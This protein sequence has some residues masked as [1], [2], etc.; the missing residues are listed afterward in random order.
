MKIYK[1]RD[2]SERTEAEMETYRL[3]CRLGIGYERV[4]HDAAATISD[5]AEIDEAL[6]T[7]MCKNLF[8]CNSQKTKFYLLLMP[9]G[10]RFKTKALSAFLQIP[11]LSF[12]S[13]EALKEHLGLLP[14]AV[15]VLGLANDKEHSVTLL[16]DSDIAD[17]EYIGCHPCVNTSSLKIKMSDIYEK[18]LPYTGH[19][20]TKVVLPEE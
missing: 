20:A 19:T 8:L 10:K 18:F 9:G 3:L 16:I 17:E 1:N 7:K 14:G 4:D 2:D 5:C 15:T 13:P 11:R 12:A 6:G